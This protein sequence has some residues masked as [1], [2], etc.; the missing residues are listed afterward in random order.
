MTAKN[1]FKPMSQ[2]HSTTKNL[3]KVMFGNIRQQKTFSGSCLE[4]FGNKKPVQG[5]VWK[6]S[7]TKNLFKVMSGNIR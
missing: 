3:F 1:N 4:T 6:H 5:P 7:L 2:R